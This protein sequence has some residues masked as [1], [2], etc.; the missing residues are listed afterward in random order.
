MLRSF[1]INNIWYDEDEGSRE[2]HFLLTQLARKDLNLKTDE[3]E[4]RGQKRNFP[5]HIS[6]I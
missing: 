2:Q 3:L 4:I 1:F 5:F 6:F